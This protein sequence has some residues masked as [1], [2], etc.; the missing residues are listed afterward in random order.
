MFTMR[1][2]E[3]H[4]RHIWQ[5]DS[6]L[7]ALDVIEANNLNTLVLHETDLVQMVTYPRSYLNPYGLWQSAPTRRGENAIENNRIYFDHILHL[8]DQRG[9]QVLAEVKEIGFPD[10]ILELHPELIKN[11]TICP[12]EPFWLEFIERKTDELYTDF[13]L[14]AGQISSAGST[15]GKASRAQGKCGCPVCAR[16]TVEDWYL[17]IIEALHRASERHGKTLAIRDFAYKPAD[18]EPLVRAIDRSPDSVIFCA[19]VTPHDFY[20]TFPH[21]PAIARLQRTKWIEYDTMGQFYGWGLFPCLALDDLN[22]RIDHATK[23]GVSGALLRVEWERINDHWSLDTLGEINLI[24]AASLIGGKP[25]TATQACANW[26]AAHYQPVAAAP[27]LASIL[28][29]TW[30][31]IRQALYANDFVFAD[32]SMY[33]RSLSRAWWGM[34]V[35]DALHTWDPSRIADLQ[36]TEAKVSALIAEKHEAVRLITALATDVRRADPSIPD[37]LHAMLVET[38]DRYEIYIDG[39]LACAEVCVLARWLNPAHRSDD[40]PGPDG[41]IALAAALERLDA[42]TAKIRDITEQA[43]LR[44]QL[45]MLIDHRRAGDIAREGHEL[46][47][48]LHDAG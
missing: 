19:K 25:I 36:M 29:R 43:N 44:H 23:S 42:F 16:T 13:P 11:G 24:A 27:W 26:L 7:R 35:R 1:A 10:E 46:L 48:T 18:H 4:G 20:L 39:F 21:N 30:P 40:G 37:S 17:G 22:H 6:I 9:I 2:L 3:L 14:L 31:I 33:P 32:N 47:R 34:E 45:V 38:F 28:S 41:P 15:E 5:R 12:S 8:A